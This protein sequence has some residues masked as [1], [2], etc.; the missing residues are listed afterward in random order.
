MY[1]VT[2]EQLLGFRVQGS[3]LRLD[4]CIPRH[5]PRFEIAYRHGATPYDVVVENPQGVCRGVATI[6]LDGQALGTAAEGLISLV[7]DGRPHRI[8]VLLG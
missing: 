7:D 5:W 6:V 2:L 4:P 1:R 3:A 8:E